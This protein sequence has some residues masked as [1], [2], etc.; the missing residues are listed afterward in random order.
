MNTSTETGTEFNKKEADLIARHFNIS[1]GH[2]LMYGV[3]HQMAVDSVKP[4]FSILAKSLDHFPLITIS[5]EHESVY[6][7]GNC[8]DKTVNAKK[9][10]THFKKVG[11]DSFSFAHGITVEQLSHFID[12]TVNSDRFP[13]ADAIKT[14]LM[15]RSA[16]TI[17]INYVVFR[18]MTTDQEVVHK[19][20]LASLV[21]ASGAESLTADSSTNA[22]S[23]TGTFSLTRLIANPK[24]AVGAL[25]RQTQDGSP[26]HPRALVDSM[27]E[28][29]SQIRNSGGAIAS[30]NLM[31]AVLVLREE[32]LQRMDGF[33]SAG[34][35]AD[36]IDAA[37]N[38]VDKLTHETIVCLLRDEYRDGE[39]SVKRLAQIL[40]RMV[41]DRRELRRLLPLIKNALL[42]EGMG[43]AKYIELVN[44]LRGELESDQVVSILTAATRD[45][46]VTDEELIGEIKKH[47]ADT[48]RL[49]ILAAELRRTEGG[50][51]AALEQSL[52]DFI[53]RASRHFALDS[54]DAANPE[55]GRQLGAILQKMETNLLENLKRQ[56]VEQSVLTALGARLTERLP[57]LVDIAKTEWLTKII[58]A[59]P[60]FDVAMLA[61]VIASTVQQEYDID[62][63]RDALTALFKQKGLTPEQIQE[64]LTQATA[65]VVGAAQQYELPK[66]VLS[67][68]VI[69][70]FLE[71]E[72]KLSLRYHNP[73]SIL[74][75][76]ILRRFESDGSQRMLTAE[77]R[78]PFINS[79][80]IRFK[81]AM[82][83]IDMVGVPASTSE[84][85]VF[86]LL[87]MTDEANTYGLV[88]RLRR[89]LEERPFEVGN[90]NLRLTLA[91]S[92]TGFDFITMPDKQAFLK[93][94]MAHHRAA[95]KIRLAGMTE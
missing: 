32:C 13:T 21:G 47:P 49:I 62:A 29:R 50:N 71:R 89:E 82:R 24:A 88:K 52:T 72:C 16:S 43:L 25:F 69:M 76:S 83:D 66:G 54:P 26:A 22:A 27:A 10:V 75:V 68:S 12:V 92:I 84:S 37:V 3:D 78:Q 80:I 45:M 8:V 94:A 87:P 79:L 38:E 23:S 33:K 46:G 19:G 39:I 55:S 77:E 53:E 2:A 86:V 5:I 15:L 61:K 7:E 51:T 64:V 41:P 6:I 63:H 14:E 70:Y 65:R 60:D 93:A 48:A 30:G 4:F 40:R 9:L 73:F 74:I 31:E 91:V 44:E 81:H 57:F 35:A 59:H 11:I 85:I 18:K 95:E 58:T 67:S 1:Y 36:D 42:A 28:V 34:A 20:A 90:L 56:G 17:R